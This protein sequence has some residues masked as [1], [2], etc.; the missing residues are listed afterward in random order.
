M[1]AEDR[2]RRD[3]E[4][5][6]YGRDGTGLTVAEAARLAELR[7]TSLPAPATPVPEPV[8]GTRRI[9]VPEPVEG[10][11]A[12][13]VPAPSP[14]PGP[15][16]VPEPVEGTRAA[17]RTPGAPDGA[18]PDPE[19]AAPR[20]IA[21]LRAAIVARIATGRWKRPRYLLGGI[22]AILLIGVGI[23]FAIPRDPD[24]GIALHDAEVVRRDA[25]LA[26]GDY[27]AGSLIL[28]DRDPA[29]LLW[30]ATSARGGI[31]CLILDMGPTQS[32]CRRADA[33]RDQPLQV[34]SQAATTGAD[35]SPAANG[36]QVTYVGYLLV[37]SN[38]LP[39]GVLQRME[40]FTQTDRGITD[41]EGRTA[42]RIRSEKNLTH[43]SLAAHW[44]GLIIWLGYTIENEQCLIVEDPDLRMS[45]ADPG[46]ALPGINPASGDDRAMLSLDLRAS[47]D[48]PSA[49][50]EMWNPI[51]SSSYLVI[52][53]KPMTS[54]PLFGPQPT[55]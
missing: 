34:V 2:E 48:R 32:E 35:P 29:A 6:A 52:T 33:L 20:P 41:A 49:R 43:V 22:A 28:L 31:R 45:C 7:A 5:R 46:S 38:G 1:T 37:S 11:R 3:L 8:E 47:G 12:A 30:T 53:E 24:V 21:R 36:A 44:R 23:G 55:G 54:Q 17:P 27:D 26:G 15:S 25:V 18:A 19:A 51:Y 13:S 14:V 10:T 16:P 4:R 39:V 50:A 42:E 9:P 40:Y